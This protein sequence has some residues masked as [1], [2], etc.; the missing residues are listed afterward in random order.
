MYGK[1]KTMRKEVY[2]FSGK[3]L[4]VNLS[5]G[6]ITTEPT[7]AYVTEWLG[8][9]GI[10]IKVLYD[11]LKS[12]VTPY[13]PFNRVIF[14][15]G[16]LIGTTAPGAN[17]LNISTLGPEM[18]GWASSCADSYLGGELKCAGY[19]SIIVSGKAHKPVY[20]WIDD[21]AVEIRDGAHVWGKTTWETLDQIRTELGDPSLHAASIGPAGEN[22]VRGAC[23]VNDRGR[24]H[25]R[26]GIGAVMGS[27]NLK[28]LVVKGSGSI[29]LAT[30]EKFMEAVNRCRGMFED[31]KSSEIFHK[32]GTLCL[33]KRK[34][35]VS[36]N[37]YKNF[38]DV[39]LP[40][41][42]AEAID[43]KKMIDKFQTVPQSYPGCAL[44]GCS[45]ILHITEGPYAGLIAEASQWE[46][47][48]T[49]Q[50]RLA[51]EEPYWMLKANVLCDQLGLGIDEA[52]G[53]IGWAIEC[54]ERGLIDDKTAG[55]LKLKWGDPELA[56]DLIRMIS[57]REG[58]GDILAEGA[59]RASDII[60]RGTGD[61][62]MHI[63][64]MDL[65]EPCRGAMGWCLGTTTSTRGG[66][67]TTGAPLSETA[68]ASLDVDKAREV[69]G[70]D[71]PHKPQEY[72][73]KAKM[74][75]YG[76]I[77]Q[78]VNNAYGVCHYNTTYWD[79]H[80]LNLKELAELYSTATGLET[81]VEDLRRLASKQLNLEKA[82][83][84]RFTNFDRKDDLPT[85][86]DREEPIPSGGFAGWKMDMKQY[87]KMLDE[88][89]DLHGWDRETSFPKRETLEELGLKNVADDLK[90]IGKLR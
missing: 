39:A 70:I 1:V 61:Y 19:D 77:L 10:A 75:A 33:M 46:S 3:V 68:D 90:A 37:I 84:L 81:T 26:G 47:V 9:T 36:G 34:Q 16:P 80:L 20:L 62:A 82:F 72:E 67:H 27:K 73:G 29:H 51:I 30:P 60:G 12:W 86:R 85:R 48:T 88:Y 24:A 22:L 49:L 63:K 54:Y 79:P 66:G 57:Y 15:A 14:G 45:R 59:A 89:Y 74:V 11:E 28:A 18:G 53:P 31:R 64:R 50:T 56:L 25:G 65:Y 13:D 35:E 71:N 32:Y 52:G 76:E 43:P 40:D 2:G 78:R 69:Y 8:A 6:E 4:R 58:F 41:D 23:V 44:G 7:E 5:N 83:N 42:L 38:Q 55:G 87:E 17:K 21:G